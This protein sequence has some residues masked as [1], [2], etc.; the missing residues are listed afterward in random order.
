[1]RHTCCVGSR[2]AGQAAREPC[3]TS[4]WCCRSLPRRPP[5]WTAASSK[6][7]H[8][9]P[10]MRTT[11]ALRAPP[12]RIT[13]PPS[14]RAQT[15]LHCTAFSPLAPI[16]A[17]GPRHKELFHLRWR[18]RDSFPPH[19]LC[20]TCCVRVPA[21]LAL[22]PRVFS[23][24]PSPTPPPHQARTTTTRTIFHSN[25]LCQRKPFTC[26]ESRRAGWPRPQRLQEQPPLGP[27]QGPCPRGQHRPPAQR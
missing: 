1:M 7:F 23:P 2:R 8:I 5:S 11:S 12:P 14:H 24:P 3:G 15:L 6:S 21:E 18:S 10:L 25:K 19:Q 16:T 13:S 22:H 4:P 17:R 27:Q 9:A 26:P 20:V